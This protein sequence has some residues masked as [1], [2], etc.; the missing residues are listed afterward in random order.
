MS[1]PARYDFKTRPLAHPDA[2]VAGEKYRF[3][4]APEHGRR[5]LLATHVADLVGLGS[6]GLQDR[7]AVHDESLLFYSGLLASHHRTAAGL[8]QLLADYFGVPAASSLRIIRGSTVSD[9]DVPS[10]ISSSSL[11]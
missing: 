1:K 4:V 11:M 5:D 6:T 2:I 8:E 10:T 7:L 3:T 9:D